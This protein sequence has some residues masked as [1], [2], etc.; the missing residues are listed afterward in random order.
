MGVFGSKG[1]T[2]YS[3][4]VFTICADNFV[5]NK[6]GKIEFSR[7]ICDTKTDYFYIGDG[8]GGDYVNIKEG[9]VLPDRDTAI[10]MCTQ[11]VIDNTAALRGVLTGRINDPR[12][13]SRIKKDVTTA[14]MVSFYD[15]YKLSYFGTETKKQF[16][17]TLEDAEK[18]RE[19]NKNKK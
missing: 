10:S 8:K 9:R 2:I 19:L 12:E 3:G 4:P 5:L 13:I 11:I 14:S 16:K 15:K 7:V 17:K 6:D 18:R 1:I